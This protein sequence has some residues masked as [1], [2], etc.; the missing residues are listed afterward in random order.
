MKSFRLKCP[1]CNAT[2][3]L[4]VE[5]DGKSSICP[6]CQTQFTARALNAQA[7]KVQPEVTNA[8]VP[9]PFLTCNRVA[10]ESITADT[11]SIFIDRRRPLLVPFIAPC[12]LLVLALVLPI[13][14]LNYLSSTNGTWALVFGL[15]LLPVFIAVLA[16]SFWF[17][18]NLAIDVCDAGP[19]DPNSETRPVESWFK[20]DGRHFLRVMCVT[21]GFL[22]VGSLT[23]TLFLF[24]AQLAFSIQAVAGRSVVLGGAF[25]GFLAVV[26]VI[27][28]RFWPIFPL[29]MRRCPLK[30]ALSVALRMTSQNLMTSFFLAITIYFILGLGLGLFGVGIPVVVPVSALMLEVAYRLVRG[31]RIPAFDHPPT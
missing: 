4:P 10:I 8:A 5:A 17:A 6:A 28:M 9:V 31:T 23:V 15:S 24:A 11:Q 29:A 19:R 13:A 27:L 18:L 21:A 22:L 2:L 7:I 30:E 3:E 25:I 1:E 16:Y 20:P 26:I 12:V 14:W